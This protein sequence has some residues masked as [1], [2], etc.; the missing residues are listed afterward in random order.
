MWVV[1]YIII[2]IHVHPGNKCIIQLPRVQVKVCGS[3]IDNK[4]PHFQTTTVFVL[5][6]QNVHFIHM[7]FLTGLRKQDALFCD[8]KGQLNR[9]DICCALNC[10]SLSLA[11][12][13]PKVNTLY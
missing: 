3:Q 5:T 1:T 9:F 8:P 10:A 6:A 7:F 4:I 13:G 12:S 2:V 11:T